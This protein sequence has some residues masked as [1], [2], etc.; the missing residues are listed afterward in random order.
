MY[1]KIMSAE[2]KP[3]GAT[4]KLHMMLEEKWYTLKREGGKLYVGLQEEDGAIYWIEAGG[5]VYVM[6]D[7]GTTISS[8][9]VTE[10]SGKTL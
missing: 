6:N 3:D 2:N 8:I 1:I 10:H 4:D 5:N 9:A 7:Q